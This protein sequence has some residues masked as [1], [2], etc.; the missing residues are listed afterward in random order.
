MLQLINGGD[1]LPAHELDG[2]LV[3]QVVRALDGVEHVPVP[4][5]RQD[6]GQGRVDPTLGGD[7][8]GPGREHLGDHRNAQ[9]GIGQLDRRVE[10]GP[11]R[12]DDQGIEVSLI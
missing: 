10:P 12:A 1:G 8:M 5:V 7:R 2:V 3:A 4:V 11:A 9:I 6:I